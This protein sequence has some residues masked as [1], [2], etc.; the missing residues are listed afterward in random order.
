[1]NVYVILFKI[2]HLFSTYIHARMEEVDPTTGMSLDWGEFLIG[3][4][5]YYKYTFPLVLY[6]HSFSLNFHQQLKKV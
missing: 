4:W 1:M 2:T 5:L 6:Y 3:Q